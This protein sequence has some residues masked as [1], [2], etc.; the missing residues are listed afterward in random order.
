MCLGC[1]SSVFPYLFN[2]V[3]RKYY[4]KNVSHILFLLYITGVL[5]FL[6]QDI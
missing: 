2:V 1:I 6:L 4:F 5:A 3:V